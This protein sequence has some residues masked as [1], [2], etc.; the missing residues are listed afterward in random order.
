MSLQVLPMK[1][2]AFDHWSF[3]HSRAGVAYNVTLILLFSAFQYVWLNNPLLDTFRELLS[4][5][6]IIYAHAMHVQIFATVI[7][8]LGKNIVQQT[9]AIKILEEIGRARESLGGVRNI[10]RGKHWTTSRV[11]IVAVA[12]S[13]TYLLGAILL[14]TNAVRNANFVD[15]LFIFAKLVHLY[16]IDA[17]VVQ[18]V[19][20]L[21]LIETSFRLINDHLV[22]CVEVSLAGI[23]E[24]KGINPHLVLKLREVHLVLVKVA[25]DVSGFYSLPILMCVSLYFASMARI[26]YNFL[27]AFVFLSADVPN[28]VLVISLMY[29]LKD[30]IMLVLLTT[31]V[32]S[33]V[34]ESKRTNCVVSSLMNR[35]SG[36]EHQDV[37]RQW[38]KN[39][40]WVPVRADGNRYIG[41]TLMIFAFFHHYRIDSSNNL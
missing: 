19:F 28:S 24:I 20:V 26:C 4:P 2:N 39:M 12:Y 35:V 27:G 31:A 7:L 6:I 17:F 15:P 10:L 14:A 29:L 36:V 23:F 8:I 22:E 13:S 37:V 11:K 41:F 25:E 1:N 5:Y 21:L 16:L 34:R 38:N 33:T 3:K 9:T 40:D 32:D 30:M 18:Y